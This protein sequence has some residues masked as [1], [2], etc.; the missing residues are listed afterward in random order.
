MV[1]RAGAAVTDADNHRGQPQRA[2]TVALAGRSNVGKSTLLNAALQLPLAIVSK[3]PQTTRDQLLG[4]IR[5]GGA[6]IGLL[7]TPG[8]H[9]SR[10]R[11][12][13]Q[14]NRSAKAAARGADVVIFVAALPRAPKGEL[15]PHPQDLE[16]LNKLPGRIPLVLVINKIDLLP[17][18]R[19]L[20]PLIQGYAQ[21]RG[22]AAIVPISAKREDGV[23]LVLDE[24]AK[25]LP[26]GPPL[27]DE[28]TITDRPLRYFA[29]EYIREPILRA[30]RQEVPHA[31]AVTV[32]EFA[33]PPAGQD[34]ATAISATIHVE[35]ASQKKILI[36]R[37]GAM[38]KTIGSAA[39][40]RIEGLTER[41]VHLTLWVRVTKSWRDSPGQL[42]QLTAADL[43]LR[44]AAFVQPEGAEAPPS[45]PAGDETSTA[46]P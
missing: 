10:S 20:L 18:K 13:E 34:G 27:Y 3:K 22:F 40:A 29:A 21:A 12:G 9:R 38:L 41:P 4:V 1:T 32:D 36:G 19:Q 28:D 8:L 24:V 39:R 6:E 33:E 7:D 11:L 14:M 30:I 37:G 15:Q 43:P 2:G 16:L 44:R 26:E 35:K 42:E 17:D 46:E 31:V 5:H 23:K 25:L 45:A